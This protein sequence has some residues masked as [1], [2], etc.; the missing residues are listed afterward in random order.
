M[1]KKFVTIAV[2]GIMAIMPNNSVFASSPNNIRVGLESIK[3]ITIE[4]DTPIKTGYMDGDKFVQTGSLDHNLIMIRPHNSDTYIEIL[5]KNG[6][7]I[8]I[9]TY[10][11]RSIAFMGTDDDYNFPVITVGGNKYRGAI[12]LVTGRNGLTAVNV[13]DVEEYLYGVV[14]S[15]MSASWPTEALKAQAVVARTVATYYTGRFD[16]Y[17]YDVVD[18]TNS[19]VYGG[20]SK[21]DPRSTSAVN[22][23]K[24]EIVM[25]NGQVA[26]ALY[27]S[28]SGGYTENAKYVWGNEVE[29]LQAVPD[30]YETDP[31]VQPWE[32]DVTFAEISN[33]LNRLGQN[34]GT[35]EAVKIT[36]RGDGGS[37]SELQIVGSNSNYVLNYLDTRNFFGNFSDGVLNSQMYSFSPYSEDF[38]NSFEVVQQETSNPSAQRPTSSHSLYVA[39]ASGTTQQDVEEIT[40]SNHMASAPLSEMIFVQGATSK[41]ILTPWLDEF[42]DLYNLEQL[43]EPIITYATLNTEKESYEVVYGDFTIYGKG[44]GHGVGMSQSGAKGMAEAGYTYKEIIQYYYQ[45]VEIR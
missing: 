30:I 31:F 5:D 25:Y 13:V 33:V 11:E 9:T 41:T 14:P 37:V 44:W 38:N 18:T 8:L 20:I 12:E 1:I 7:T 43:N 32:R 29:Y 26:E 40:V 15:E 36:E 35:I 3:T 4:S 45:G 16:A 24:G 39:S 34:I 6:E 2:V 19:Q 21:E 17:G 10:G 42:G 23:T 27:F 28:T 22:S